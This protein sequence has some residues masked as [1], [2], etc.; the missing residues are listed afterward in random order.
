M[1]IDRKHIAHLEVLARLEL[2]PGEVEVLVPQLR[3]IVELVEKLQEVDTTGVEPTRLIAHEA[4]DRLR[5]DGER[6]GLDRD[7]VL[8]QAPDR[9]GEFFR[10]PRVLERGD[11]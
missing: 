5:A 6:P 9:A 11:G 3:R 2:A 7:V 4:D 1:K 10:V 8:G